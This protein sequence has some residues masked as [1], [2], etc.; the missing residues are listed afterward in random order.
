[1]HHLAVPQ[2]PHVNL[3]NDHSNLE[4]QNTELAG[5]KNYR[6]LRPSGSNCD[7]VKA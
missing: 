6:Q 7:V 1:M 2:K 4:Q 3:F 5:A